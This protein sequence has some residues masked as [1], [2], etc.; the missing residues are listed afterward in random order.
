V[1]KPGDT[2]EVV[3]VQ[4]ADPLKEVPKFRGM[5]CR[6]AKKKIKE[7]GFKVGKVRWR[8]YDAPPYLVMKQS[9]DPGTKAKPGT[10]IDLTC[11]QDE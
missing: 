6:K 1:V 2:V 9:P 5:S 10:P 11:S 8:V 3:V 7:L 4:A